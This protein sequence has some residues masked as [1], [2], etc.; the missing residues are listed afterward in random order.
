M[1]NPQRIGLTQTQRLALNTSLQASIALLRTDAAGLTRYLEEQA[2][3]N[4]HLRLGRR[5]PVPQ[6]WLPR[7]AGAFAA[8]GL[9][10]AGAMQGAAPSLI[11]HVLVRSRRWTC[12]RA[13]PHRA[14][15]GRGAGAFGLAWAAA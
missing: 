9:G 14:G 5:R 6:D 1:R 2:A 7:W 15:T 10:E 12:R 8:S 11:A 13:P 3:E 4:P